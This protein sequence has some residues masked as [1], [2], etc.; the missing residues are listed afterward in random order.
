M[1]AGFLVE[2]SV[3]GVITRRAFYLL[4]DETRSSSLHRDY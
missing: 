2:L 1:A 3:S 4:F